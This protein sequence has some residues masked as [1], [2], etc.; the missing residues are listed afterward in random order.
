MTAVWARRAGKLARRRTGRGRNDEEVL[1]VGA[2]GVGVLVAEKGDPCAVGRPLRVLFLNV[3][4][5]GQLLRFLGRDVVDVERVESVVAEV[6]LN[7]LLEVVAIDDDG[8]GRRR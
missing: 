4:A 8:L 7:V 1:A 2:V 6:A 3:L 5:C